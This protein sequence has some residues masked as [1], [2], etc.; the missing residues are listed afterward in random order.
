[1]GERELTSTEEEILKMALDVGKDIWQNYL[2]PQIKRYCE[3]ADVEDTRVASE[4]V[5]LWLNVHA[6]RRALI[7]YEENKSKC[8]SMY[9]GGYTHSAVNRKASNSCEA[10][11]IDDMYPPIMKSEKKEEIY[12]C[13]NCKYWKEHDPKSDSDGFCT[14]NNEETYADNG[15]TEIELK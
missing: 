5:R 2:F 11:Y 15:C 13:W 10:M 14:K 7:G 1:M 12:K 8:G 4:A 6:E 9:G 3:L